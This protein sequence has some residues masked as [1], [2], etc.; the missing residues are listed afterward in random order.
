MRFLS[1]ETKLKRGCRA[2]YWHASLLA[3]QAMGHPSF[4]F[5]ENQVKPDVWRLD[6]ITVLPECDVIFL[7]IPK[8]ANSKTKR[9]LSEVRGVKNPFTTSERKKLRTC[10]SAED[11]SIQKFHRILN[12]KNRLSFAIVRDP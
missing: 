6:R 10:L 11:I 1:L 4:S 8:N 5:F 3:A 12:S 2:A 7:P 9:I